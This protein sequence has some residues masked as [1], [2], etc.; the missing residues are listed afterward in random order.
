MNRFRR[1]ICCQPILIACSPWHGSCRSSIN[2]PSVSQSQY[3]PLPSGH[4]RWG[5]SAPL[6]SEFLWKHWPIGY[7]SSFLKRTADVLATRLVVVFLRLFRLGSF[8]VC[9]RPA[10]FTRIPIGPPSS[11]LANY[12]PTSIT[13]I[14]FKVFEHLVS[15]RLGQFK[16]WWGVLPTTQLT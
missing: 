8:P 6:W 13:S 10:N 16:E 5:G 1:Q 2:V 14:L 9:R 7:V 4:G 11:S 3:V 15:V 12:W